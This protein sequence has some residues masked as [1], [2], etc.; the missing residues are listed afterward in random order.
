MDGAKFPSILQDFVPSG[1]ATLLPPHLNITNIAVKQELLAIE[2]SSGNRGLYM[3][4]D[5]YII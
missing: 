3:D 4:Q 1:A 2:H 5:N